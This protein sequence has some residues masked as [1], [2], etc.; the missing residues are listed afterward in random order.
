MLV[1][2]HAS[3]RERCRWAPETEKMKNGMYIYFSEVFK[4]RG[5]S[6]DENFVPVARK[7]ATNHQ[8]A[9]SARLAQITF[10]PEISCCPHFSPP[11]QACYPTHRSLSDWLTCLS[12]P[13]QR[14]KKDLQWEAV[15]FAAF[16]M[17]P[18]SFAQA[19]S[20]TQRSRTKSCK[21]SFDS[22]IL[23][24]EGNYQKLLLKANW[25]VV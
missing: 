20:H 19:V 13:Q 11:S 9:I 4:F 1:L 15:I 24:S 23:G 8:S 7:G 16:Q 17:L 6:P 10:A 18:L 12:E 25:K 14:F 3:H 22:I 5:Q 21:D 2:L